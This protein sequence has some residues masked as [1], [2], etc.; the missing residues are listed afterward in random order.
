MRH[1]AREGAMVR[2]RTRSRLEGLLDE[3]LQAPEIERA[4]DR[5]I[6][7]PLPDAVVRSLLEHQVVER[8][9][10]ELAAEVDVDLAVS[11]ALELSGRDRNPNRLSSDSVAKTD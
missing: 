3:A 5:V 10:V 2:M 6:A 7:G 9:A 8:L 1:L 11:A 4:V